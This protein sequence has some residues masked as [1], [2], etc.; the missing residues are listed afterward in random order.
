M[1]AAVG[2]TRMDARLA[3]A[4][5]TSTPSITSLGGSYSGAVF[6]QRK[7]TALTPTTPES[8]IEANAL[9]HAYQERKLR[10]TEHLEMDSLSTIHSLAIATLLLLNGASIADES[11]ATE[12]LEKTLRTFKKLDKENRVLTAGNHGLGRIS[13]AFGRHIQETRSEIP[14]CPDATKKLDTW[15]KESLPSRSEGIEKWKTAISEDTSTLTI[16]EAPTSETTYTKINTMQ[17]KL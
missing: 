9:L 7:L 13:S 6:Y 10:S 3:S 11:T 5:K 16:E 4:I 15:F 12:A 14:P 8:F 17:Q 1:A 2:S